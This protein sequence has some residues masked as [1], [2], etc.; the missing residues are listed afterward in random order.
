MYVPAKAPFVMLACSTEESDT[1]AVRRVA[2]GAG[3]YG[4]NGILQR[5]EQG[6]ELVELA[7]LAV[8]QI[9]IDGQLLDG[10]RGDGYRPFDRILQV[11]GEG[12]GAG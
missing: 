2:S 8:D 5:A 12:A 6:A 7:D 3:R 4:L 1:E 10:Q 9:L 11:R